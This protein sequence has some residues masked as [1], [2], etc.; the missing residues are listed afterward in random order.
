MDYEVLNPQEAAEVNAMYNQAFGLPANQVIPRGVQFAENAPAR[1]RRRTIYQGYSMAARP[2]NYNR[3]PTRPRMAKPAWKAMTKAAQRAWKAANWPGYGTGLSLGGKR[4]LKSR[5]QSIKKRWTPGQKLT[6][7]RLS[8][9]QKAF[10][11]SFYNKSY[12]DWARGNH[13]A[14]EV[15]LTERIMAA[16]WNAAEIKY[17]AALVNPFDAFARGARIPGI[18]SGNSVHQTFTCDYV[19]DWSASSAF[20]AGNFAVQLRPRSTDGMPEVQITYDSAAGSATPDDHIDIPCDQ[21]TASMKAQVDAGHGKLRVVGMGLK[22]WN[23]G[24]SDLK[25]GVLYG[26]DARLPLLTGN[27]PD[28][29]TSLTDLE[30]SFTAHN[31]YMA[32]A[33]TGMSVR[34][35]PENV[36]EAN[37]W[38]DDSNMYQGNQGGDGTAATNYDATAAATKICHIGNMPTIIGK[39]CQGQTFFIK[40]IFLMEYVPEG[41]DNLITGLPPDFGPNVVNGNIIAACNM[42][43]MV[44]LG[45]S[46]WDWVT[47]VATAVGNAIEGTVNWL[48]RN[49]GGILGAFGAAKSINQGYNALIGPS[50]GS[51]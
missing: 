39:N 12:L 7:T 33:I 1:R 21:N 15:P 42:M 25:K 45:H 32:E 10:S 20:A 16:G 46:F 44:A 36:D 23:V 40:A 48:N 38:W 3:Y 30:A 50:T 49:V 8:D 22:V 51:M 31:D 17:C 34:Y 28:T 4:K 47:G 18:G 43:T 14:G 2:D 6:N 35:N 11:G 9:V 27:G 41:N 19:W 5:Y 26:G 24:L 13:P 29:F 37:K